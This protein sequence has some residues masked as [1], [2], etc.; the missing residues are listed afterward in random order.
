MYNPIDS[1]TVGQGRQF[2]DATQAYDAAH[3]KYADQIPAIAT[4]AKLP[5]QQMPMAPAPSP[6]VLKSSA[7]GER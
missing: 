4:E 5:T 1:N 6:F 2:N 7:G 3:G